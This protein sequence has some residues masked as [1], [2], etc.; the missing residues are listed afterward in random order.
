[1]RVLVVDDEVGICQVVD[2]ALSA[3][4]FSCAFAHSG[5]D[6]LAKA[7]TADV[8]VLDWMLPD[9]DGVSVAAALRRSGHSARVLLLTARTDRDDRLAGLA[10]ADD[11]LTKPFDVD[12]LVLRVRNLA[13]R[14]SAVVEDDS[15]VRHFG[16]LTVDLATKA[17]SVAAVPVS[18]TAT[19]FRLLELLVRANGAVVERDQV[20]D[21]VW[22][23]DF[24]GSRSNLDTLVSALRRKL[25]AAGYDGVETVR[26]FGYRLSRAV[27]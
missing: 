7:H 20:Y 25:V 19:E 12:E 21:G 27:S 15:S 14:R 6:G 23:Y 2:V 5:A 17:A 24:N 8:V 10:V 16:N 1:M 4:G 26:G 22:G 9:L 13:A 11:Y 18:L 3:A